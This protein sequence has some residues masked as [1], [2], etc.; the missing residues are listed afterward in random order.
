MAYRLDTKER[1]KGTYMIIEKKYWDKE[2]KRSVS[3]HY[4]TLGYLH[5]L[6]KDYSDPLMYFKAL[7]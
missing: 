4:K 2:K 3:E 5:E 7:L 1:K 6:Q